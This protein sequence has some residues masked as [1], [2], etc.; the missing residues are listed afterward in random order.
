MKKLLLTLSLLAVTMGMMAVPAKRGMWKTIKLSDGTEVRAKLVG[1]EHGHFWL[2][3]NGDAYHNVNGTDYYVAVNK[4]QVVERAK[5]R[6]AKMNAKRVAKRE[7]GHPTS[8]TGKKKA[9]LI[10]VNFKDVKFQN[11]N[12]NAMYQKIANKENF[13]EGNFKGS[14]ADYFK[15]QSRG[16]FELDF[17]VAGPVTVSQNAAYYGGNN[18]D[19]DDEDMHPGEMV[20]E[21]VNLVKNQISWSQYDWDNDGE[22]DQV[23][24]VYA[25]KG[26]ADGGD[27][28]T[29]WPHAYDLYTA[30]Y[31]GD[32]TGR[33]KVATN[34]YVN[35]YACGA[36]LNGQTGKIAGIGTMCHEYSHCLGYPDFYDTGYSGGQGMCDW[37]L[38]DGGSYNGDGYQPAGYTSYERWFAGWET[39]ITLEDEDVKVENMKSL[40]NGGESYIIY[41][42]RNREEYFLLENRQFEGWDESLYGAGLLILHVDHDDAQWEANRP[43]YDKDHQR[44]TWIPADKNYKYQTYEGTK[45]YYTDQS[46]VFP[47]KKTNSFN[48]DFGKL[49]KWYNKDSNGTY[50]LSSSVENITQNDD[51]TISFNFIASKSEGGSEGGGGS[52]SGDDPA[53]PAN[54]LFYESF[55]DCDGIGGND[56]IW[57]G[58]GTA[59]KTLACDKT[60]W[61]FD[62]GNG[63]NQCAKFG[64]S[65]KKGTTTSPAFSINGTGTLTFKAAPWGTSDGTTLNLSVSKGTISP[66]S[67]TM[68]SGEWTRFTA[69]I[70]A[71]GSVRVTFTPSKRFFLD[72]VLVVDPNTTAIQEVQVA[73]PVSNGRIYTLDGRYV[74]TDLNQLERGLYIINGKKVLK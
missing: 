49:A 63:A 57:D 55:D 69:T 7:F 52:E 30:N 70:T 45:Y 51:G 31:Y 33:V 20:I 59:K 37:D 74:G 68:K 6:R 14:M 19:A 38:M 25:G 32:G 29:I 44:M 43:N 35:G 9:L 24:V 58:T 16:K 34:L 60:G 71:T 2:S 67:V 26:E 47:Y 61:T 5:S 48:K 22:V 17:D 73:K 53:V 12:N 46:D 54:N 4:E 66:S 21:A 10:L 40:Q 39:P 50:Y 13:N 62:S 36:E 23:Y 65:K 11:G 41:N 8:Y 28:N 27:E 18:P 72:D 1:D 56:D 64:S 42:K 3:E 15:A